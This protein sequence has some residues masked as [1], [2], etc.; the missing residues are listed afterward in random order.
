M[1]TVNNSNRDW[2]I[3][4]KDLHVKFSQ[5]DETI[6]AVNGVD[7]RVHKGEAVGI[8]GESG[9]GKTVTSYSMLNIL[10]S[11]G[12]IV[13]GEVRYREDNGNVI[14][15][16]RL[17][18]RSREMRRLRGGEIAMIFQEP[19]A[20]FSPVHTIRDQI[21]EGILLH[22]PPKDKRV[23]EII[24]EYLGMVGISNP[25]RAIDAYPFQLSGGM[26]QRA[27]I[28]MALACNPKVLVADEPTTALDVTIQAQVL[29]LIKKMQQEL[30]LALVLITHDLGVIAHMADFVY[31]MYLGRVVERGP[32][33]K[34]FNSPKHPYTRDL[35]RSIPKL[36]TPEKRL[37]TIQGNVPDASRLPSGCAFHPRCREI[38]GETCRRDQPVLEEVEA[39]HFA[40]C[41]LY[42]THEETE[43]NTGGTDSVEYPS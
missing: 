10:P 30:G 32:V 22:Q 17:N 2:L 38:I 37:A 20:S 12:E 15:I 29:M 27:M 40:G 19:M 16:T 43:P 41:F 28:A 8:V 42:S 23:R 3:D 34:I 39:D 9:C 35:I 6:N 4:I 31:V 5:D 26:R 14:D 21:A 1:N 24:I 36:N 7:I 18:P 25:E 11:N 33:V 13:S